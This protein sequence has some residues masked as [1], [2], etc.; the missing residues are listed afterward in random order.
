MFIVFCMESK[1]ESSEIIFLKVLVV[2]LVKRML[3]C[4]WIYWVY[5]L[6][7]DFILSC[8]KIES[9]IIDVYFI[10]DILDCIVVILI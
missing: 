4:N 8:C 5:N 10:F 7:D 6:D 3:L 9:K 1:I 2:F